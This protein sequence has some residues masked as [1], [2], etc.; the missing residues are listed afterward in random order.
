MKLVIEEYIVNFSDLVDAALESH[1]S[2]LEYATVL[3][4]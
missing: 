4:V 2:I 1:L 3:H